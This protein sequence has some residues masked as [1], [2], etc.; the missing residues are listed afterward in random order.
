MNWKGSLNAWLIHFAWKEVNVMYLSTLL[1]K[2][3]GD[4]GKGGSKTD[5]K[6]SILCTSKRKK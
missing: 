2:A 4:V 3:K 6:A 1:E 5:S